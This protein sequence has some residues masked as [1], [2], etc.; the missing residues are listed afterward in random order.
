MTRSSFAIALSTAG[1]LAASGCASGGGGGGAPGAPDEN[2]LTRSAELF[3]TQAETLGM[4]ERYSEALD[5]ALNAIAND[6]ANA[7]GYFLAGRAQIGLGD[8]SAADTLLNR[9][10]ERYAAYEQDIR[11]ERERAWIDLFNEAIVPLDA[12]DN[13]AGI[14]LLESAEA[15]FPR[16][17]PEALI[18]LGVSYNNAGR[19]DDAID[20]YAAALEVIRGPATATADSATAA[21]W[22][23]REATV[24]SNRATLLASAERFD[25]AEAAWREYI[26]DNP[27]D[28]PARSNLA[29]VLSMAGKPAEAQSIYDE[30]LE[31]AEELG[32][33][34]YMNIG[35]GL[36]QAEVFDRAAEAF[37]HVAEIAPENRDAVFNWAQSL[38][39][40][41]AW[42]ELV[43][44][45]RQ[46]QELDEWNKD[47]YTIL[48]RALLDAGTSEEA[49]DI[50]N[51]GE[52]LQFHLAS[53]QLQPSSGGASIVGE[54][55]NVCVDAGE[56][57]VVRVHFNGMDGA[58]LGTTEIQITAPDR[59]VAQ[60]F[61]GDFSSDEAVMGYYY[62]VL[63]PPGEPCPVLP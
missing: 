49:T 44:V 12:G 13:E 10:L 18:N 9:A 21:G 61:R 31:A 63:N 52:A 29:S 16:Q 2:D 35:I 3:L 48:A 46:L 39:E 42:E 1:I 55:V 59:D 41:Q 23:E 11:V 8:Y 40:A 60:A 50:Y 56:S 38:F 33:R 17:R 14:A 36:Y 30:L 43:P 15:I 24:I 47:S 34:E 57:I 6:T 27:T 58:E 53:S 51:R 54:F 7:L 45:A 62:E 22:R 32:L 37:R 26:A 25:E 19:L 28:V 5:A 4:P 20:A